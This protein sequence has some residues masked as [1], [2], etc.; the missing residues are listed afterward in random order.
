MGV[1][2]NVA[3][4]ADFREQEK[5]T[6][7]DRTVFNHGRN[8]W[9]N[10]VVQDATISGGAILVAVLLWDMQNAKHRG[11]WPSFE[12][13]ATEL[14][15]TSNFRKLAATCEQFVVRQPLLDCGSQNSS[16]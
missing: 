8:R 1:A 3:K 10:Q 12:Y 14:E 15:R 2:D 16:N 11:A 7:P 4:L 13:M 5:P 9:I 6:A